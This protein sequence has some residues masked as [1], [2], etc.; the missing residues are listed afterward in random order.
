MLF[1]ANKLYLSRNLAQYLL[2]VT[3]TVHNYDISTV[4]LVNNLKHSTVRF[5]QTAVGLG[6][7]VMAE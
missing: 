3:H 5:F 4:S 1:A 7:Q 2:T 6:W